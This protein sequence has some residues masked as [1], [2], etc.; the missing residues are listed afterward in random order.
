MTVRRNK[1]L[2]DILFNKIADLNLKVDRIKREINSDLHYRGGYDAY[3]IYLKMDFEHKKEVDDQWEDFYKK[4][5]DTPQWRLYQ[6]I[7]SAI[8]RGD[9]AMVK[10]L[11]ETNKEMIKNAKVDSFKSE[12]PAYPDPKDH[13]FAEIQEYLAKAEE[14]KKQISYENKMKW[15]V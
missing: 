1:N 9:K 4:A 11:L 5:M 10:Y 12:R 2:D 7:C 8:S 14:I 6:K 15:M 13:R 3:Q